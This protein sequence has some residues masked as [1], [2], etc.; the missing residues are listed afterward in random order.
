MAE[1]LETAEVEDGGQ[2]SFGETDE[3]ESETSEQPE[4]TDSE[5]EGEESQEEEDS[6]ETDGEEGT[7]EPSPEPDEYELNVYGQT[8]KVS[9]EKLI[10]MAERGAGADAKFQQSNE[11]TQKLMGV[12]ENL[13]SKPFETLETLVG[14]ET[15][16]KM[17]EDYVLEKIQ[18]E[19][20]DEKERRAYEAEQKLKKYEQ[21]E[22]ERKEQ[23][24]K[25]ELAAEVEKIRGEYETQFISAL[26]ESEL[27]NNPQIVARMAR[28]MEEAV[29][30]GL[31]PTA[32]EVAK[33]VKQDIQEEFKLLSATMKP[34]QV[35]AILGDEQVKKIKEYDF[36]Q[37]K[38]PTDGN[39]ADET[40]AKVK[41]KPRKGKTWKELQAELDKQF[42]KPEL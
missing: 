24:K 1:E 8:I 14:A 19:Q 16:R 23:S 6:G 13:K 26:Q 28:Y 20:M 40:I 37:V 38:S 33:L 9:K 22:N 15:A 12:I 5:S 21:Q 42:G 3:A 29:M 39:K 36:Q 25:A 32:N 7:P 34:D 17:T 10:D 18:M 41:V 11:Q 2:I 4:Q 27:P 35:K 31:N 30:E